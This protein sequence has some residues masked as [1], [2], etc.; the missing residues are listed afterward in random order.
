MWF[1]G[2]GHLPVSVLVAYYYIVDI[3]LDGLPYQQVG[4]VVG[5]KHFHLKK[6]SV[7]TDDIKR[8]SSDGT[9]RTEYSNPDPFHDLEI[10]VLSG[11]DSF[12]LVP[13]LEMQVGA[14]TQVSGIA[15]KCYRG[16]GADFVTGLLQ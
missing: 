3:K 15:H 7:L 11:I 2:F 13:Q 14:G 10:D 4:T 12:S 1:Q 6:V 16:S 5:G 8:L 9:G